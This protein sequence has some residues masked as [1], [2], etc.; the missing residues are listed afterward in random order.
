MDLIVLVAAGGAL[1]AVARY[2]LSGW[3]QQASGSVSF[4][5]GTLVVNMIGC[6]VIGVLS[7]LAESRGLLTPR[8]RAF[9]VVGILGGFTTFSSFAN[10]SM[11]LLRADEG[12]AA[13]LNVGASVALGLLAVWLGRSAAYL[14]WR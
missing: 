14:V 9:L 3:V 8:S 1:G 10:E 13:A 4:P 7:Q 2:V 5:F 11:N 12:L 6:F